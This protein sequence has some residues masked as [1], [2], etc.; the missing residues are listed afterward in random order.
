[1]KS[2]NSTLL[3]DLDPFTYHAC[4]Q[5][6]KIISSRL[7]HARL[8][9]PMRPHWKV[10]TGRSQSGD[11][12]AREV[13]DVLVPCRLIWWQ[14]WYWK[15]ETR[16]GCRILTATFRIDVSVTS[17]AP[18]ALLK[19]D[20]LPRRSAWCWD[21]SESFMSS[22]TVSSSKYSGLSLLKIEQ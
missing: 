19:D 2:S 20:Q 3:L 10:D 22:L 5:K 12:T 14:N 4:F 9:L 18:F 13:C 16:P 1:M 8:V 6:K 15:S 21:E 11:T 7:Q 17:S